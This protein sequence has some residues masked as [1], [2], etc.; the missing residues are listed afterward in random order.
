VPH[1]AASS[2]LTALALV[3]WLVTS[4]QLLARVSITDQLVDRSM[5]HRFTAVHTQ[6]H[7]QR[8]R[9]RERERERTVTVNRLQCTMTMSRNHVV[10]SSNMSLCSDTTNS[11]VASR[12]DHSRIE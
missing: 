10:D 12:I 6:T 1:H 2:G 4:T 7:T 11:T 3:A 8:E 9:E 5:N